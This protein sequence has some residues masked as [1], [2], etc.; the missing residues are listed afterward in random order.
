MVNT[1]LF[2]DTLRPGDYRIT[3]DGLV[4]CYRLTSVMAGETDLLTRPYT[5]TPAGAPAIEI[6]LTA[7]VSP[8]PWY[9]VSG[10]VTGRAPADQTSV[11]V[12]NELSAGPLDVTFYLDGSFDMLALAGRTRVVAMNPRLGEFTTTEFTVPSGNLEGV[13]I[14]L[15]ALP[16]T[17]APGSRVAGRLSGRLRAAAGPREIVLRP[18]AGRELKEFRT[19]LFMD[20]TFEFPSIQPGAYF[21]ET[22]PPNGTPPVKVIINSGMQDIVVRVDEDR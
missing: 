9:K 14:E 17:S 4:P 2:E 20:G 19:P 8:P 6:R 10:R 21:A 15:P 22:R 1:P 5:V 3:V 12:W 7:A 16:A 18:E 11:K 13:A